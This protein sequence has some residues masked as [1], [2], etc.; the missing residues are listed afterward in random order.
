MDKTFKTVDE[1]ASLLESRGVKTDADTAKAIARESYY[2][3]VNGYKKPF[4]DYEAMERSGTDVYK[5]GVEFRW[6]YDLFMFD[7]DL[8][9]I[10]FE[11]LT[12][13]EA[14]MKTAVVYS[15]CHNH[16]EESAYLDVSNFCNSNGIL[17]PKAFKGN[18]KNLFQ[19]NMTKLMGTLNGKLSVRDY[20]A[21]P[22]IRHYVRKHGSVPL[23]VLSND[24]TFG[25]ITHFYQLM[26]QSDRNEV[27]KLIA[28]TAGGNSDKASMLSPRN[29]LRAANVLVD[30]RNICAH[31]ERLYCA[32]SGNDDF[33]T[34]ASMMTRVLPQNEVNDF[35]QKILYL[36]EVYEGRLHHVTPATLLNDM[37][38]TLEVKQ[39]APQS[40]GNTSHS[41]LAEQQ[42]KSSMQR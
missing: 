38:F 29:L 34:M 21:K 22:F 35:V 4:L 7:R 5:P 37:G 26:Q 10:T 40:G 16:Q 39:K 17:V 9:F 12:R 31:D 18:K 2:A 33:A 27:C 24:L 1:L 30:F 36:F 14:T 8:R 3:I 28:A 11:Y 23:W 13:A 20:R 42:D 19:N 32:K 6:M 41:R 25:N 15:F